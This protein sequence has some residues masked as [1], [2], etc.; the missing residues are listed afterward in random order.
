MGRGSDMRRNV[1][2]VIAVAGLSSS[3]SAQ[4][5]YERP[6][7]ETPQRGE[8]GPVATD[9]APAL[10]EVGLIVVEPPEPRTFAAED[11]VTIVISER[12][13]TSRAQIFDSEKKYD[14]AGEVFSSIDLIKMLELRLQQ[15][16]DESDD[17]PRLEVGWRSKYEGDGEYERDDQVTARVT[18]RVIEVKP[19]GTMLLEARTVIRTDAEEQTI[20]LSGICRSEDVTDSNTVQSNQMFDLR[21]DIQNSGDVRRGAEKGWIPRIIEA[22]F[23]F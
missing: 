15:G 20:T 14:L 17:L 11:L 13:A 9:G 4:S 18:A 8:E 21:L 2:I 6:Q 22:V 3:V 10:S 23:N 5:L 7:P 12:S 19:N 1:S 16:R